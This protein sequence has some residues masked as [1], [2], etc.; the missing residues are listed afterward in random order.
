[1][2]DIIEKYLEY[3]HSKEQRYLAPSYVREKQELFTNKHKSNLHDWSQAELEFPVYFWEW[4]EE[5]VDELIT[6]MN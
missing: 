2:T 3:M 5:Y 6:R 4:V 1:M